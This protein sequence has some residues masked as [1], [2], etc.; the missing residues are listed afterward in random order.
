MP[1]RKLNFESGDEVIAEIDRLRRSGY[2][3]TG[4]WNLTQICQHLTKTIRL[5]LEGARVRMPWL[6]RKT[7]GAWIFGRILRTGRFLSN[8]SAPDILKPEVPR[9]PDDPALIEECKSWIARARDFEGPMPPHP[10]VDGLTVEKWQRLMWI[11]AA[12]H[13]GFLV[14]LS[15]SDEDDDDV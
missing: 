12:H 6:I 7:L 14:P 3:A 2:E 1:I 4:K 9:G 10:L 11:H 13:L 8:V 5:G 15:D